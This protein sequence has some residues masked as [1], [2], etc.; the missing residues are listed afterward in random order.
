MYLFVYLLSAK[1][2]RG[3]GILRAVKG[4]GTVTTSLSSAQFLP[5]LFF[6]QRKASA[7]SHHVFGHGWGD[8]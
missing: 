2:S 8:M 6:K 3:Y 5:P 4:K 1:W 7:T